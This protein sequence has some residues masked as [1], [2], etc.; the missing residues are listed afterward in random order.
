MIEQF[1][2]QEAKNKLMKFSVRATNMT[3]ED[4]LINKGP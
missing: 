2:L 1:D 3:A 4:L